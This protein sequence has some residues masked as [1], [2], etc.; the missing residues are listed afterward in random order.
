MLKI[1][2]IKLKS[3]DEVVNEYALAK[4]MNDKLMEYVDEEYKLFLAEQVIKPYSQYLV[5]RKNNIYDWRIA[6]LNKEATEYIAYKLMNS[7]ANGYSWEFKNLKMNFRVEEKGYIHSAT[8]KQFVEKYFTN[9]FKAKYIEFDFLTPTLMFKH[10]HIPCEA[11]D[12]LMNLVAIWNLF[13]KDK[14]I[15]ESN[16]IDNLS[17]QTYVDDY[18]IILKPKELNGK[19]C[20]VFKGKYRFGLNN[21]IMANKIIL[22]L[23]EFAQY[24]GI[25]LNTHLGMGAVKVIMR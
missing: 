9:R 3:D 17:E 6:T 16:L 21:N 1:I 8:Y 4:A 24:A 11:K 13:A 2:E 20:A 12:I 5:K 18:E 15:Y 14:Q 22:M 25:G 23:A 7:L 19:K 10:E